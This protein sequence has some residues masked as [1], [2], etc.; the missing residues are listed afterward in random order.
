MLGDTMNTAARIEEMCRVTGREFIV[1]EAVLRAIG[2]LPPAVRMEP[3]GEMA[4]RGKEGDVRL[5]ALTRG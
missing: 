3:L 1:S 2:H 4:L 5:S